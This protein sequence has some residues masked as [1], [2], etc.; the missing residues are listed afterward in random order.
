[1]ITPMSTVVARAM[2]E[3]IYSLNQLKSEVWPRELRPAHEMLS[4]WAPEVRAMIAASDNEASLASFD[5]LVKTI[6]TKS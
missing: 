4:L 2:W 3:Y 1:M 6:A 5:R